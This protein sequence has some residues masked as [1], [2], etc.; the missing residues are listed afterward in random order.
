MTRAG[1]TLKRRCTLKQGCIKARVL[2]RAF[3]KRPFRF[4]KRRACLP[5]FECFVLLAPVPLRRC[6]F[7]GPPFAAAYAHPADSGASRVCKSNV[8]FL[9]FCLLYH[10][11]AESD[12]PNVG[13]FT[14]ATTS[15]TPV[16]LRAYCEILDVTHKTALTLSSVSEEE[17]N[18]LNID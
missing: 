15:M 5:T 2:E 9:P 13:E 8:A 6:P 18:S 4:R 3:A 12:Q 17:D 7:P 14:Y 1:C 10:R 11:N 16:A